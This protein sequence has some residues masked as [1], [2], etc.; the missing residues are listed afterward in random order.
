MLK[1]FTEVADRRSFAAVAK[2]RNVDPSTISRV[3]GQLEEDLGF[4]LFQRT[5]R[6]MQVTEAG[7]LYL[8]QVRETLDDLER[9]RTEAENLNN[10]AVGTL[11]IT[12]SVT[13]GHHVIVPLLGDFRKQYPD[14]KIEGYFTD[15]NIDLVRERIDLSIRLAPGVAGDFIVSKLM[16]T[17]YHVVASPLY[18]QTKGSIECPEDISNHRCV[19]FTLAA[20]RTLWQFRDRNG[21]ITKVPVGGDIVLS[22]ALGVRQAVLAGLGPALLPDWLTNQDIENGDLVR[23]LPSLDVT[24]T[25]FETGAFMIYPSRAYLPNKVRV[26]M[27]FLRAR[28]R[29]GLV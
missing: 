29:S 26:M 8:H 16:D 10:N 22:N 1:L 6:N 9:A 3:V 12:A 19:L 11:R 20:F 15:E 7:E 14:V 17:R 23:L 2:D 13:F 24:A 4:R 27:D 5:T 21:E 28:V 25:T 18:L